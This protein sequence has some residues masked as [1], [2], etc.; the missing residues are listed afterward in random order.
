MGPHSFKCGKHERKEFYR[1]R[2]IALQWGRTLSSAES[3]E[4]QAGKNEAKMLQWG[5]TL[6]SAE[7]LP[8]IVSFGGGVGCFNGAALF[9][10]RKAFI[11]VQLPE[12]YPELQWGRTLSSAESGFWNRRLLR[13][14]LSL[15]WGRTLSSA[16]SL[17]ASNF[18]VAAELRFNGA[19]LF[20]VRKADSAAMKPK[21]LLVLQWGRTLSSAESTGT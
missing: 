8:S 11:M 21:S 19:A 4:H 9:Q 14:R 5:R 12:P 7:S 17:Y 20:Q 15:Q 10:V 16:E 3:T 1:Q 18:T 2:A 6:S 13:D